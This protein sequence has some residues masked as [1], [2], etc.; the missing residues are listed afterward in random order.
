MDSINYEG[1]IGD[2]IRGD[3]IARE[4][5]ADEDFDASEELEIRTSPPTLPPGLVPQ[6][7]DTI[8]QKY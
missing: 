3:R 6:Q 4:Q 1:A 5:L 7:W 2:R 8:I